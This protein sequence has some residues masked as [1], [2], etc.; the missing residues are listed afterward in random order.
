M[1]EAL[2]LFGVMIGLIA[3]FLSGIGLFLG[4]R[5]D[6]TVRML[7]DRL[8]KAHESEADRVDNLIQ[9]LTPPQARR[10]RSGGR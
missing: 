8:M 1:S 5:A 9:M 4:W 2:G 10:P 7:L 6:N 3:L